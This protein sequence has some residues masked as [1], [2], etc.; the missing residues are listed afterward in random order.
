MGIDLLQHGRHQPFYNAL[1]SD[2]SRRYVA[3][4]N[5]QVLF[6]GLRN[7]DPLTTTA[8]QTPTLSEG[9]QD[10][11]TATVTSTSSITP[12]TPSDSQE[13]SAHS[14]TMA[15]GTFTSANLQ[16]SELGP[17]GIEAVGQYFEAWDGQSGHYI[18]NKELRKVYPTEDYQYSSNASN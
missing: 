1:L 6:R 13:P 18:M 12:E 17:L 11:S 16:S 8:D 3:Q 4:E 9:S 5:I 15:P 10:S 7:P 14:S 2:G